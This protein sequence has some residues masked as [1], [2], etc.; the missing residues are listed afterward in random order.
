MALR[1]RELPVEAVQFHPE[2][3]LTEWGYQM[4]ANWLTVCGD[5]DA[6]ARAVGMAP[7]MSAR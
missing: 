3:V 1:H 4:L 7:L 2:S 5:A 6:P